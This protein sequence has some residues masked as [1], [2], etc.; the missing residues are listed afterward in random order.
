MTEESKK[1]GRP[2][3]FRCTSCKKWELEPGRWLPVNK[4][5]RTL[6]GTKV[7]DTLCPKCGLHQESDRSTTKP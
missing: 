3:V 2:T 7:I 6:D 4:N 1:V 5:L